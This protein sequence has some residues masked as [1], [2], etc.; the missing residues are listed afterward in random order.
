MRNAPTQSILALVAIVIVGGCAHQ[1]TL[2]RAKRPFVVS[3][4]QRPTAALSIVDSRHASPQ[5]LAVK[6][7][8]SAVQHVVVQSPAPGH[9]GQSVVIPQPIVN[10]APVT[11]QVSASIPTPAAVPL[12]VVQ[13]SNQ[14]E[15]QSGL[16]SPTIA[17]GFNDYQRQNERP[18]HIEIPPSLQSKSREPWKLGSTELVDVNPETT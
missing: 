8:A 9:A 6:E 14:T 2:N 7:S 3:G 4:S 12:A 17:S 5:P 15:H 1:P 18:I 13:V 10:P 16:L 11:E